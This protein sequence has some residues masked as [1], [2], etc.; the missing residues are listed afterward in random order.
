MAER[1][2]LISI[3][4]RDEPTKPAPSHVLEEDTLDGVARAEAE[5]LGT[6]RL[7]QACGHAHEL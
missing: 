5:D 1:R 6:L 7:D 3:A 4:S 2:Q